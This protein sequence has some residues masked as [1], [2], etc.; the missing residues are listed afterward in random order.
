MCKAVQSG[1]GKEME[2]VNFTAFLGVL[3]LFSVQCKQT[4]FCWNFRGG[5]LWKVVEVLIVI[6]RRL[7]ARLG[8]P[9]NI[10]KR[11]SVIYWV[12]FES[13]SSCIEAVFLSLLIKWQTSPFKNF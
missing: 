2:K 7:V 4:N 13:D 10:I 9:P 3:S 1:R 5:D 6:P 8:V 11:N 12:H